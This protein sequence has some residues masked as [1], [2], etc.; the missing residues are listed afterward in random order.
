[1][2]TT[3]SQATRNIVNT[4]GISTT[5]PRLSDVNADGYFDLFIEGLPLVNA[6]PYDVVVFAASGSGAPPVSARLL[7]ESIKKFVNDTAAYFADPYYFYAAYQVYCTQD[8]ATVPGWRY[9]IDGYPYYWYFPIPWVY[10]QTYANPAYSYAA[11][12]AA[13]ALKR[14]FD[15]GTVQVG[16]N[17]AII[18]DYYLTQLLGT[19]FMGGALVSGVGLVPDTRREAEA[20]G[21]FLELMIYYMNGTPFLPPRQ[22]YY[23]T[24]PNTQVI[25][26]INT[27]PGCTPDAVF[28]EMR[29]YPAIGRAVD[30]PGHP[31]Q[32]GTLHRS[33]CQV[34]VVDGDESMV[35]IRESPNDDDDV[36]LV[37]HRVYPAERRLVNETKSGHMLHPGKVTRIVVVDPNGDVR[38]TTVGDGTG[39]YP[40]LNEIGGPFI[41]ASIDAEIRRRF[42][43]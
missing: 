40:T 29:K 27:T 23:T 39:N 35:E 7:D 30:A 16:S 32:C 2:E 37:V 43:Q 6:G 34:P 33:Q 11:V 24:P 17:D 38:I 12:Q 36:G 41:F 3:V 42:P 5:K 15:A 19:P 26:N 9:D 14:I 8:W 31:N 20:L 13:P 25:C 10:C 22:H 4:W 21:F 1:V 18:V 28:T